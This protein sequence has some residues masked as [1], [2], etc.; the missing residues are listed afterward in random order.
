MLDVSVRAGIAA[1]L[2]A[3]R[4]DL[5]LTILIITHDLAEAA[6]MRIPAAEDLGVD[7]IQLTRLW[8]VGTRA[9]TRRRSAMTS[10]RGHPSSRH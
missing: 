10:P 8:P 3:L 9:L 4:A 1:T 5:G 2:Q 7:V 6:H